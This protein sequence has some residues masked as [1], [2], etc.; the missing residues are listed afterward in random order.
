MKAH[1][2]WPVAQYDRE[3]C[4]L[5]LAADWKSPF[6]QRLCVLPIS[7][8]RLRLELVDTVFSTLGIEYPRPSP[9]HQLEVACFKLAFR[10]SCS[11]GAD[12][13]SIS[14]SE[15]VRLS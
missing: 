4:H 10:S 13:A 7:F 8:D 9:F 12:G 2:Q 6:P 11:Y 3:N 15:L 5:W 14:W 1:L